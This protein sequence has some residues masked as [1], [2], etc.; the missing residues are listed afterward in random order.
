MLCWL[1]RAILI[2]WNHQIVLL[3]FVLHNA[4]EPSSGGSG[5]FAQNLSLSL[6]SPIIIKIELITIDGT[7]EYLPGVEIPAYFQFGSPHRARH[8]ICGLGPTTQELSTYK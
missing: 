4:E 5:G 7:D 6:S 8:D 1:P 2:R 3:H